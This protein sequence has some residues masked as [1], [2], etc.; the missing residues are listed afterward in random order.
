MQKIINAVLEAEK[1]GRLLHLEDV[2]GL[3]GDKLIGL[4][5]RCARSA[6]EDAEGV[7]LE[8]GVYKGLSLCSV[9]A[10]SPNLMCYGIDNFSQFNANKSNLDCVKERLSKYANDNGVIINADYEDALL[11]LPRHIGKR[12]VSVYFIDGPHDYRSQ[13][14]CLDFM[15]PHLAD[16]AVIIIDDSNYEHVRQTNYDWLK[17]N[18]SYALLYEAYTRCHPDK[19]PDDLRKDSLAGWWNGVNVIVSD[20]DDVFLRE[21]PPVNRDRT[22]YF[23]EHL[24][25]TLK[26]AELAPNLLCNF[27]NKMLS[28]IISMARLQ[29]SS[30]SS[31]KFCDR[32]PHKNT[33]SEDLTVGKLAKFK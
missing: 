24:V 16:N 22:R 13:Y 10:S 31:K 9:A 6:S 1:Y 27:N 15:R 25:H 5:Q 20:P 11:N 23:N 3:S 7:Y 17:S 2:S 19:M 32:M 18:P 12:K 28:M 33:Y 21:Y 4:L 30:M 14:L 29:Y 8:V 26:Y